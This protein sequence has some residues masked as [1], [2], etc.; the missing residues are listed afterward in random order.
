MDHAALSSARLS[1][2][3]GLKRFL[4]WLGSGL[5]LSGLLFVA[6]RLYNYWVDIDFK[7]FSKVSWAYIAGCA[8]AYCSAN[9]LLA[10]AWRRLL[11]Q[12]GVEVAAFWAFRAYGISQLAKYV[13]GNIFHLA[14][15]QAIGMA[16]GLSGAV[17]AKS[18]MWEIGLLIAAG[19]LFGWLALPL[20]V[21]GFSMMF[22]MGFLLLSVLGV[23]IAL[24][25]FIG[26]QVASAF[27]NQ[28]LFL[29]VSALIFIILLKVV[30]N[31]TVLPFEVWLM[32]GGA[33]TIAW[34]AG[35]MTPGAPAGVGVRELV[36]I[37]LLNGMIND[38]QLLAAVLIGRLVTV[39]G[40]LIFYISSLII[41]PFIS[42]RHQSNG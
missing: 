33:Y 25:R 5:A 8:F 1:M 16:A 12:L 4:H 3:P 36:L 39:A 9:L 2:K 27:I 17:M 30:V 40:D 23:V 37:T 18:T 28:M 31:I 41:P 24:F 13:P 14:G 10:T 35:L 22:C 7:N 6:F 26:S 15:R 21:P 34:L 29:A 11:E 42:V 32:M 19:A 38:A 20:L